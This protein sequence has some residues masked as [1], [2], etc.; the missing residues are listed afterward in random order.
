MDELQKE[1]ISEMFNQTTKTI[2][3]VNAVVDLNVKELKSLDRRI[4][5]I[6]KLLLELS[7]LMD[8]LPKG[9]TNKE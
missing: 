4:T 6:E 8:R 2:L 9:E 3:S 5:N 1:A 7:D